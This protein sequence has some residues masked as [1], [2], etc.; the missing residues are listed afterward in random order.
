[1][2]KHIFLIISLLFLLIG[3]LFSGASLYMF[4]D[5]QTFF[6]TAVATEGT[7]TELVRNT[8]RDSDGTSYTY[9]PVFEFTV[10]DGSTQTAK[11]SIST[12][13]PAYSIGEE[14]TVYY[15]P[16]NPKKIKINSLM[17]RWLLPMLF[18]FFGIIGLVGGPIGLWKIKKR[19]D[20][21]TWLKSFGQTVTATFQGVQLN[22]GLTVNGQNP[23][24]IY[25]QWQSPDTQQVYVFESENLWYDPSAF[26]QQNQG[27]SITMD[28][29]N[30]KRYFM[31]LSFLPE[32]G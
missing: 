8:S 1:M 24:K 12:S 14:V 32:Q 25:A 9:T 31:N 18:G 13:H 17:E 28:P 22:T 27:I 16:T 20:E 4:I 11:S 26:L 30:P 19:N 2:K 15:D 29:V 10:A 3:V 5:I 21:I 7:V 6:Q 23:W